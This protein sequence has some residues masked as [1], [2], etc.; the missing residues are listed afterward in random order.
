VIGAILEHPML[1]ALLFAAF[2][3]VVVI[4]AVEVAIARRIREIKGMFADAL[5]HATNMDTTVAE[6]R[7]TAGEASEAAAKA[8]GKAWEL[9]ERLDALE[10]WRKKIDKLNVIRASGSID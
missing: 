5:I 7:R 3:V 4:L 2:L 9:E 6:A 10:K 8:I 1:S